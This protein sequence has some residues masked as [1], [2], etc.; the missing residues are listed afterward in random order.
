MARPFGSL[1]PSISNRLSTWNE[2]QDHV[3]KAAAPRVRPT[4]TLSREFG[5]EGFV[6]ADALKARLEALSGEPWNV[7]DKTLLETVAKEEGI[8]VATLTRLGETARSF[9]KLGITPPEYHQ[10][11]DAFRVLAERLV[12]FATVGNAI[13]IGRGGAVLCQSLPNC[14]HVRIEAPLAWR[15]KSMA[16]RLEMTEGEASQFVASHASAREQ[17]MREQLRVDPHDRSFFNVT[18]NNARS[19]VPAMTA[20][21]T[22]YLQASWKD[23]SY[24]KA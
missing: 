10:H 13:V 7:Y 3:T 24:F 5:C 23:Q 4:I 19:D 20:A 9:E 16:A 18:F 11:A 21:I 15:V 2:I 1:I 14:F 22:G 8:D 6:L 17:F 12:Q